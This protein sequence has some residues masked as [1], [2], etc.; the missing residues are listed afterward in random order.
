M[1][2]QLRSDRLKFSWDE[3]KN[4]MNQR[5]HGVSFEEA[6]QVF[7]DPFHIT[8]QDR[9]EKGDLRW[10]TIGMSDRII[11]LLVAH[12]W[13]DENKEE[14]IRIISARRTTRI[15]RKMYEQMP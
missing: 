4:K 9:T 2:L 1:S 6:M 3:T 15:E 8:R 10:Q 7:N 5:K 11:I 12:T 14:H 13:N